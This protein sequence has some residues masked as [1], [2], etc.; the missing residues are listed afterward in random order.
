MKRQIEE[1]DVVVPEP[2]DEVSLFKMK[3]CLM[4]FLCYLLLFDVEDDVLFSCLS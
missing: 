4:M 2:Y 3:M 1:S